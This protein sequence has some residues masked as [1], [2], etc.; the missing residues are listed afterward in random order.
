MP[1]RSLLIASTRSSRSVVSLACCCLD[2]AQFL[3]GAQIDRAET[4]ALAA[5][6]FELF[7]DLGDRR[8]LGARLDLGEFGGAGRLDLQHVADFVADVG[9]P[10]LGALEAFLGARGF[11]ARVADRFERGARVLVGFG[12][13]VLGRRQ[14]VG[15]GAA[16]GCGGLDLADQRLALAGEFLRR[17]RQFGAVALGFLDALPDGGDLGRGAV[18]A[19]VPAGRS[20]AI[21]CSRRP[22]SSASRTIACGSAR[23]SASAP[24]SRGD[25]VVDRGELGFELGGRRQRGKRRGRLRAGRRSLRRGRR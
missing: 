12:E 24:R 3:L 2:L 18:A 6:A 25:V 23:T 15:I 5:E 11:G 16:R 8:Q 9:K 7:F 10:A 17:V 14:P 13:L 21:A 4:L 20:A 19:L 22:A 1:W